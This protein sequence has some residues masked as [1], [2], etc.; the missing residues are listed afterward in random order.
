MTLATWKD[1]Y[2]IGD[3]VAINLRECDD[4]TNPFEGEIV[5]VLELPGW[6][7]RNYV[8]ALETEMDPLLEVRSGNKISLW[9]EPHVEQS[10]SKTDG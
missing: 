1:D 6:A 2:K 7:F 9:D 8:I 3:K 10:G 4:D 5:A